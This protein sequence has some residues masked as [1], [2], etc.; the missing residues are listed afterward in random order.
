MWTAPVSQ[1]RGSAMIWSLTPGAG[2]IVA[3]LLSL[4]LWGAIWLLAED[5]ARP[6]I[7]YNRFAYCWQPQVKGWTMMVNS[8]INNWRRKTSPSTGNLGARPSCR[9]GCVRGDWAGHRSGPDRFFGF[10][11]ATNLTGKIEPA[12]A[13]NRRF[14]SSCLQR[15]VVQTI[16]SSVWSPGRSF[17]GAPSKLAQ[18]TEGYERAGCI[19]EA[20]W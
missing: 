13:R 11:S 14:E 2:L 9:P 3:L 18:P 10:G 17:S 12:L 8:I 7:F 1:G 19:F 15:R 16:G 5:G 6:I 20:F 4:G